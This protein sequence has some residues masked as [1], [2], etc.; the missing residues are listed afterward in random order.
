MYDKVTY[1]HN[2]VTGTR[3]LHI[4]YKQ[5]WRAIIVL[6]DAKPSESN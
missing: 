5:Y 3:Q 1:F 4:F 2:P 6:K